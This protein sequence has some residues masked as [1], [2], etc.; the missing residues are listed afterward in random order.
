MCL[1]DGI[2]A[3]DLAEVLL[4][5]TL[6]E[7]DDG[8][9]MPD[10][11]GA[12]PE[13]D[14]TAPAAPIL[15][16]V[17]RTLEEDGA[18]EI[19]LIAATERTSR[20][21]RADIDRRF[22]RDLPAPPPPNYRPGIRVEYSD[23]AGAPGGAVPTLHVPGSGRAASRRYADLYQNRPLEEQAAVDPETV[24]GIK[25]GLQRGAE[26]NTYFSEE[27]AAALAAALAARGIT[28]IAGSLADQIPRELSATEAADWFYRATIPPPPPP[29]PPIREEPGPGG[30]PYPGAP[31]G[32]YKLR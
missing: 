26:F 27:D 19:E 20:T 32:D 28:T 13:P 4:S 16:A 29:P 8:Y 30:K 7:T 21:I 15:A 18:E 3:E 11:P 17:I 9:T 22:P 10:D 1:A 31:G 6:E 12:A 23:E 25:A 24:A 5:D 2:L 14:P